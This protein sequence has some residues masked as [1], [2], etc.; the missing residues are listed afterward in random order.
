MHQT[1]ISHSFPSL[2]PALA[3]TYTKKKDIGNG[4]HNA[5]KEMSMR[6][7]KCLQFSTPI[8]GANENVED[9][10][11]VWYTRMKPTEIIKH[12]RKKGRGKQRKSNW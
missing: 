9:S 1:G 11:W 2:M 7:N 5:R 3:T 8:A 4:L 6:H 10:M 12:K